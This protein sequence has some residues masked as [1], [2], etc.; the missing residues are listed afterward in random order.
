[1]SAK[2][3]WFVRYFFALASVGAGALVRLVLTGYTGPGLPTYVTFFPAIMVAA[4]IGGM[5][6][7]LMATVSVALVVDF[8]F[9]PPAGI[10][11]YENFADM[12]GQV[13][14]TIVGVFI[15]IIAGR[16][17][18]IRDNLE[19]LVATRTAALS[20]VNEQLKREIE[21]HMQSE[22]ALRQSEARL[23]R[24]QE[25][26]NLG[27]WELDLASNR[28]SLSDD[29]Y[30]IIG[31]NP[32]E[33]GSTY[34]A[35]LDAVHPDDR[36]AVD[37]TL[38]GSL[39]DGAEVHRIEHRILRKSD[40]EVRIVLEKCEHVC[41]ENGMLIRTVGTVQDITDRKEVEDAMQASEIRYRRLFE[42]AH[43]GILIL[44]ADSGQIVDVNPF[45]VNM[46]GYSKE[47]FL[48]KKLWEI[49]LFRNIASSKDAFLELQTKGYV[50]Y[51]DL[52]LE[53][54][55]GKRIDVE[56][57]SNVYLVDR[58]K[59]IQCNIRDITESKAAKE[60]LIKS[61]EELEA[62]NRE[63]ENY[64]YVVS[65]DLKEPLR[66]IEGF[67]QFLNED[68]SDKLGDTGKEYL[69]RIVKASGRMSNLITD[70]L[71]LSRIGHK[72]VEFHEVNL[73]IMVKG[74]EGDLAE[75]IKQG[76]GRIVYPALPTVLCQPTWMAEV[77]RNLI[78]NG[79]KFNKSPAPTVTLSFEEK[80]KEYEF[81]VSDNG[82]G[83]E[84]K[85]FERIFKLF[86]R[87]HSRKEYEGSGAGLAIV[88]SII[89]NHKGRI[90]VA[91]SEP[92]KGTTFKFTLPKD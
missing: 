7:G 54:K 86:E 83:I 88:K 12:V 45:L 89:L 78:S 52:P 1:M 15:S 9:L 4:L 24:S 5:G 70:L 55:D 71:T 51:D 56:V 64:T 69:N 46:L 82:I 6:P 10:F 34:G 16:Y 74:I 63:L 81:S 53:T 49:G 35:F 75:T 26:A 36:A 31:I 66:S 25:M 80:A 68:Y 13:L 43:E 29:L 67:S 21:G 19:D 85:Y 14:F 92:G 17:R 84:P 33:F 58:M 48:G 65:H 59:V 3:H 62:V 2:N 11:L 37:A 87:L 47:V 44:D 23:N 79:L 90:W 39:C 18:Q 28:M 60:A 91:S 77:F 61:K 73:N 57:V 27:S 30:K 20:Q 41:D 32:P 8:W 42:A 72:D 40:G 22:A 38:S 76:S 50:R